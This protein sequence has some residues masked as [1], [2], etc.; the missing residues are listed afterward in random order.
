MV[1]SSDNTSS[2]IQVLEEENI[3]LMKENKDLRLEISRYRAMGTALPA[4]A[5]A[6]VA[7]STSS[8]SATVG[9][10][11]AF[12]TE[13]SSAAV[14]SRDN[15][16]SSTAQSEGSKPRTPAASDVV[17]PVQKLS[18]LVTGGEDAVAQ[19]TKSQRTKAKPLVGEEEAGE[20]TQS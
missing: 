11:R 14:Q 20:C 10:K 1:Q 16:V 3:E 4:V 8:E 5:A 12:G 18:A 15:V 19:K 2:E 9:Q 13:L 7:A 17:K 6:P